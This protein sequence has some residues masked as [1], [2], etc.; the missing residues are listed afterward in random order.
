LLDKIVI[1]DSGLSTDYGIERYFLDKAH[2]HGI[3]V[4]SVES[5]LMQVEA[6]YGLT[7][8]TQITALEVSLDNLE[9]INDATRNM[10][11]M[12]LNWVSGNEHELETFM[13][14]SF[15]KLGEEY[16]NSVVLN[17]N[18]HM[19]ETAIRYMAEEKKVFFVVG[20]GHLIGAGGIIDILDQ[21]GYTVSKIS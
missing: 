6:L 21:E 18:V 5:V 14:D 13:H 15:A 17:R 16:Y 3:E 20:V 12:Y 10:T 7:L 11:A 8:Q 1:D 4:L 2:E 9:N 19:A